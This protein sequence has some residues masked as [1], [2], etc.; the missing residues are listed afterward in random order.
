MF[1]GGDISNAFIHATAN[2]KIYTRLGSKFGN[3]AGC[4]AIIVKA[5]YGLTTSA[6]RFRTLLA[7]CIRSLGFKSFRLDRD[8]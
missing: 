3:R 4:I 6:E 1:C 5:L 2:E 7:Y 8:I